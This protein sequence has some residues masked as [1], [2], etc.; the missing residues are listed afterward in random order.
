MVSVQQVLL[1]SGFLQLSLVMREKFIDLFCGID[2][3]KA[4]LLRLVGCEN[5]EQVD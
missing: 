4:K 5:V 1:L 3:V 2:F